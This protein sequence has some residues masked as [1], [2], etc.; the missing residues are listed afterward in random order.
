MDYIDDEIGVKGKFFRVRS[1][2]INGLILIV[3]GRFLR[4]M[5]LKEEEFQ[6]LTEPVKVIEILR[7]LKK[8][9][10]LFTFKQR[11]PDV[12]SHYDFHTEYESIAVLNTSSYK[13]W[14]ENRINQNTKRAIE[15]AKKKGIQVKVAKFDRSFIEGMIE[16]FNESPIRQ[17]KPFW[18]YGK[19]YA[20]I[21]REFS[22]YLFREEI[23]GAYWEGQLIGFIFLSN[24]GNYAI[25]TQILSKMAHRDKGVMNILVAKAVEMCEEKKIPFIV[26]G[27]WQE[28]GLT[29]FK[30]R[31]GF[32]KVDIPRYYVP[33]T[34]KGKAAILIGLHRGWAGLLPKR[35]KQVL[36]NM[37]SV[38]YAHKRGV[39]H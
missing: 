3:R 12:S 16:I 2:S 33:L 1:I 14:A 23:I 13:D 9:P 38:W 17:N 8:K 24:A 27:D 35:L 26:Y 25:P 21:E 10:D 34:L 4:I 15:K 28:S 19:D 39:D 22:K 7:G 36:L 11:F 31:N 18:H 6:D 30:R 20:T 29:E 5:G 32:E 37:R